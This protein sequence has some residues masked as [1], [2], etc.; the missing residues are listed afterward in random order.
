MNL[1]H[2]I[3]LFILYIGIINIIICKKE[4][5]EDEFT[6]YINW[7]GYNKIYKYPSLN[8]TK[9]IKGTKTLYK[10][11]TNETIP[12]NTT[13]I[14]I[15]SQLILN[16][17]KV[18]DLINSDELKQQ[19]EQFM[20]N[21]IYEDDYSP[22]LKKDEAFLSYIFYQIHENKKKV[23]RTKFYHKFKYFINSIKVKE[24]YSPFFFDDTSVSK[25]YLSYINTLYTINKKNFEHETYIFKGDEYYKKDIDYD[26]YLPIR[27]AIINTGLKI[28]EQKY[29]VPLINLIRTDYIKY[30]SNFTIEKDGSIN[31]Y[32]TK[33]IKE[34]EEI[35]FYSPKMSNAQR[36]LFEGRT[37]PE[38]I[39]YFDE[40]L[41]PAFGISLYVR[42]N[43]EDPDLEFNNYINLME[44]GFEED[45]IYIYKE[46]KDILKRKGEENIEDKSGKGWPFEILLNN[47]KAFKEYIANFGN[48]KIYEYF[49]EKEDRINVE[50]VILGDKKILEK[51]YKEAE[52]KASEYIDLSSRRTDDDDENDNNNNNKEKDNKNKENENKENDKKDN[53]DNDKTDL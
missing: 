38:L 10:L 22:E 48:D 9:K 53:E 3:I 30:N 27:I 7:C 24:D 8:F 33:T 1:S 32:A 52:I 34:N 47:L 37:Y 44:E 6:E 25:L 45:A 51:A 4:K 11:F 50:R 35:I 18:L 39:D 19:Y 12:E 17:T 41:V 14:K 28:S 26:E 2:L 16:I 43:I 46:H 13:I 29:L 20:E 36:L 40:Y 42:F 31:I 15:P 49:K 23:L 5:K 21:E